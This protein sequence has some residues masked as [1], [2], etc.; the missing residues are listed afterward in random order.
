VE[1]AKHRIFRGRDPS[2]SFKLMKQSLS[3][4]PLLTVVNIPK[5]IVNSFKNH[6]K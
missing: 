3:S 1:L 6:M 5:V 2:E 4:A